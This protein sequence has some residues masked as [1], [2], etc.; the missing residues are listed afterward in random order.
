MIYKYPN[1]TYLP[2][3]M[4]IPIWKSKRLQEK[5]NNL[6]NKIINERNIAASSSLENKPT[7]ETCKT[8]CFSHKKNQGNKIG[9]REDQISSTIFNS[10]ENYFLWLCVR[11]IY[12]KS[13]I[14]ARHF[15]VLE[16]N[17][18]S[19]LCLTTKIMKIILNLGWYDSYLSFIIC[20]SW[21]LPYCLEYRPL[22]NYET[23][24]PLAFWPN[25]ADS[26]PLLSRDVLVEDQSSCC[27]IWDRSV[28][29]WW[30]DF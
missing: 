1:Y 17:Q 14:S 7:N 2:N 22:Y 4:K 5:R 12:L 19:C 20:C 8:N 10:I 29:G 30:K 24:D 3:L 27:L 18:G 15:Q 25:L 28:S 6:E 13:L 23:R 9:K 16:Y 21:R 11:S 26:A